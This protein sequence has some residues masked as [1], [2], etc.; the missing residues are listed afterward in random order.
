MPST[1]QAI[2]YRSY[3]LRAPRSGAAPDIRRVDAVVRLR[4]DGLQPAA[5]DEELQDLQEI[6]AGVADHRRDDRSAPQVDQSPER[7]E[8]AGSERGVGALQEVAAAERDAR[9]DQAHRA[10]AQPALEPV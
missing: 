4:H 3:H 2:T 5:G 7:A 8:Q 10:A 6:E 9:H 1:R